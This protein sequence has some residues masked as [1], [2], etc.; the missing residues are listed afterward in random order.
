M[1][2]H[3]VLN[4]AECD[5]LDACAADASHLLADVVATLGELIGDYDDKHCRQAKIV[6]D[7]SVR[8]DRPHLIAAREPRRS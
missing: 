4:K 6:I 5:R 3:P 2:S 1:M 8:R 7:A